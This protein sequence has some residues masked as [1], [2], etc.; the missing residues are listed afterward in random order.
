MA[1]ARAKYIPISGPILQEK[2]LQLATELGFND[3]KASAGWLE[4]WKSRYNIGHFKICGDSADVNEATVTEHKA[5]LQEKLRGF[6]PVDIFNCDESSL[7]FRA[8]PD[9]TFEM[10]GKECK[11]GK[12][13]KERVTIMLACSQT[14]EKLKPLVIGKAAKTRC[15][16]N[17]NIDNLP[18]HWES[19]RRS[20]MT[21][22][23]FQNG[24]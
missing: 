16:K 14:G 19:N 7:F 13:S 22:E 11:G 10:R 5:S 18:V 9:K 17:I 2:A 3:F 8:L 21:S 23:I 12:L 24:F 6:E 1:Q 20:L 4:S 15:F